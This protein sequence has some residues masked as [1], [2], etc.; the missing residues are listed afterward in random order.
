M[1]NIGG[2]TLISSFYF[3]AGSAVYEIKKQDASWRLIENK[4]DHVFL[5]L[6]ADPVKQ[7]RLYGGTFDDGLFMSDDHGKTWQSVGDGITHKRILS[8]TVSPTEV[9]NGYSVV[10]VGTEPSGLFRSEDGGETWKT[11]PGLLDLP[12]KST[13]SFP[14]RP[15]THHVRV[16]QPDLHDENK[17]YVGIEL[18]G[19]MKSVDQGK[20]WE[21]RKEGSQFDSHG[22]TMTKQA[23]GRI[24][25]SAGGGFAESLDGGSTWETMNVGLDP[26]GYLVEIAVDA[27][28]PDVIIASAAKTART[29]YQPSSAHSVIVRREGNNPWEVVSEGLPEADGSAVFQLLAHESEP[30]VFYAVNNT[31]LYVSSDSGLSWKKQA[32][33]WPEEIKKRQVRGFVGV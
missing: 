16:I 31:G 14:P 15:H 21:D 9:I 20:S 13:W 11:F 3:V 25:E 12:S 2:I 6:T 5:C 22:L 10:W 27:G 29:A 8:V 28:N 19:V 17:I 30:G 23:E 1:T 4:A 24:Y 18:G 33:N 32:L 26:Y 7:G